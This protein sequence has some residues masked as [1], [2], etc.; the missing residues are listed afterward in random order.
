MTFRLV[1]TM[2]GAGIAQCYLGR[3]GSTTDNKL[4]ILLFPPLICQ[5]RR[6]HRLQRLTKTDRRLELYPSTVGVEQQKWGFLV[7]SVRI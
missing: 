2:L 1:I 6:G 7:L 4:L 3:A 5:R